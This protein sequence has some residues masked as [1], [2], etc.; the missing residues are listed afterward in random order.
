M[1]QGRRTWLIYGNLIS[2]SGC[3]I[4]A[5]SYGHGQMIGG[6]ILVGLGNGL[7]T[8]MGPAY[9]AEMAVDKRQRGRSVNSM[10]ASA[11][12]GTASAYW[13]DFGMVFMHGQ[14][15][16]RFPVAFQVVL[17]IASISVLW[18]LPD[19]PRRYYAKGREAEGDSGLERL[20]GGTVSPKIQ[21]DKFEIFAS[22]ELENIGTASLHLKDFFWNTSEMQS[23]RRI[24]TGMIVFAPTY[25]SGYVLLS[26]F[27]ICI[28]D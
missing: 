24:R 13:V 3:V 25:L 4:C 9:V 20:H 6:S 21:Q 19:T 1:L 26:P 14:V 8:S 7:M 5:S 16:W 12:I 23:A 15:I 2:I 28:C 27:S 22:V 10:I 17:S 18:W 11:T